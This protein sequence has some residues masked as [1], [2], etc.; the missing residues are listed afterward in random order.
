MIGAL[1][2]ILRRRSLRDSLLLGVGA[3]MLANSL[4]EGLLFCLPVAVVLALRLFS[5]GGT[6]CRLKVAS[7][8]LPAILVLGCAAAF[9]GYY[10]WR[11]TGNALLF[12]HVLISRIY[13]DFPGIRLATRQARA[14]VCEPPTHWLCRLGHLN[15]LGDRG[16]D[17]P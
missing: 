7:A 15:S 8:L 17:K 13:G 16:L 11:V 6:G 5:G 2:R 14:H 1:P 9:M 3:A 4:A 12:P 10:N